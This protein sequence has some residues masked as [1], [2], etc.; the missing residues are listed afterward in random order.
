METDGPRANAVDDG[1]EQI[2]QVQA[3][4]A[5]RTVQCHV[6]IKARHRDAGLRRRFMQSR[7]SL[8]HVRPTT[9]QRPGQA[10][11]NLARYARQYL[12]AVQL[13]LERARCIAQQQSDDVN[14]LR[15]L[16]TQWRQGCGDGSLLS[17][18][19]RQVERRCDSVAE[20][21]V[22]QVHILFG[23]AKIAFRDPKTVLGSAQ[24]HVA[25]R[26]F[27]DRRERDAVPVLHGRQCGGIGG[28]HRPPNATEQVQ[29]P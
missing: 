9:H 22:H 29:L 7:L 19:L 10:H 27:G 28:F 5:D 24:L 26:Q 15:L 3:F 16:G 11:R 18:G 2:G 4:H 13:G 20:T 8:A 14:E 23:K 1:G 21:L 6:R 17:P 25:L 12:S